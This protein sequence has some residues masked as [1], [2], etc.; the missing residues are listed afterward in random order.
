[1]LFTPLEFLRRF[2][3]EER[4]AIRSVND[5]IIEDGLHLLSLAQDV[6]TDNDDT[7]RFVSYLVAQGYIAQSA[8]NRVMGVE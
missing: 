1:M 5:V 3:P 4:I 8:Y 7:K 6:D 2:T